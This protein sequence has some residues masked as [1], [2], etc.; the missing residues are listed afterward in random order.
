MYSFLTSIL[1][2]GDWS[3]SRNHHLTPGEK[4]PVSTEQELNWASEL[5]SR[6]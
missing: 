2:G 3:I 4:P 1:E 6:L 5:V